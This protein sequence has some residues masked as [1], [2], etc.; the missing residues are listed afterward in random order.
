M[1]IDRPALIARVRELEAECERNEAKAHVVCLEALLREKT[2]ECDEL[3][4]ERREA[5][6]HVQNNMSHVF[7]ETDIRD[8]VS[9]T[10]GN[11]L[12]ALENL[13]EE[14]SKTWVRVDDERNEAR[15][16]VARLTDER[17]EARAQLAAADTGAPCDGHRHC[18]ADRR[19]LAEELLRVRAE[20]DALKEKL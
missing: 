11:G 19:R 12:A 15:A 3:D 20:R 13:A 14:V 18:C 16:E 1:N 5:W 7:L 9:Y 2:E 17:D 6:Q 10:G 4:E 8:H